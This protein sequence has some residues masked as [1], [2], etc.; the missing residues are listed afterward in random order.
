MHPILVAIALLA[1]PE[2]PAA[3]QQ[4]L[5]LQAPP[6]CTV[7]HATD[8]GG[9][10]TVVK[11]FGVYL[12]SRGLRAFDESSLRNALLAADGEHHASSGQGLS[13]ID[14]LKAGL[15]PNGAPGTGGT[16]LTPS[17]GCASGGPSNLLTLL[18]L[19]VLLLRRRPYPATADGPHPHS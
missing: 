11:P 5:A 17:F 4:D 6:R 13:D 14:A 15:D 16:D 18:G 8:S 10:G 3:I 12:L 2:F 7:C 9:A 1:T 19:A